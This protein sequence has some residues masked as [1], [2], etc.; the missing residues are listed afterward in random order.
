MGERKTARFVG[1][2]LSVWLSITLVPA[3]RPRV[4]APG[5][6]SACV[7]NVKDGP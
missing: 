2:L 1:V 5:G 3:V 6:A 7:D 4:T